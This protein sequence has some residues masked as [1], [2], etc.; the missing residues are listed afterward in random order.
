MKS[1]PT[2][3]KLAY[4]GEPSRALF[5][6]TEQWLK[7]SNNS[8]VAH[9]KRARMIADVNN[10]DSSS[11]PYYECSSKVLS[12][13][14]VPILSASDGNELIGIIDAESWTANFF[15]TEKQIQILK[16]C[17]DLGLFL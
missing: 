4:I 11:D 15:D 1:S 5:P 6:V 16:I 7:I 13:F 14:C 17:Y 10:V 9:T 12:E 8:T 2:L 3:V